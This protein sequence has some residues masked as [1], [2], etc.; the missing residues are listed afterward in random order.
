M[1]KATWS[2]TSSEA[3]I[4][5]Q[6][7]IIVKIVD[8]IKCI[9]I[10]K[11]KKELHIVLVYMVDIDRDHIMMKMNL[12]FSRP[13]AFFYYAPRCHIENIQHYG[14][15]SHPFSIEKYRENGDGLICFFFAYS[16]FQ[17]GRYTY[18]DLCTIC[19]FGL[20]WW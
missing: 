5:S 8:I 6:T 17:I 4:G 19:I 10:K 3:S 15:I 1:C 16:C 11:K 14:L 20:W 13:L 12:I 9:H 18:I 7:K 2:S